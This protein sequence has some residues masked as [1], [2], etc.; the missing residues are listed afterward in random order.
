MFLNQ[1]Q[2]SKW[3]NDIDLNVRRLVFVWIIPANCIQIGSNFSLFLSV[4]FLDLSSSVADSELSMLI[5]LSWSYAFSPTA[6]YLIQ[7][8][9]L[10]GVSMFSHLLSLFFVLHNW[11]VLFFEYMTYTWKQFLIHLDLFSLAI[12]V[13][14]SS[15]IND[16]DI[17]LCSSF[18]L[19]SNTIV[20]N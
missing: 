3:I 15:A 13:Q 20:I 7:M 19:V 14:D 4:F 1:E 9:K 12:L 17:L 10:V 16:S 6:F 11:C 5:V 8:T 2:M 18:L